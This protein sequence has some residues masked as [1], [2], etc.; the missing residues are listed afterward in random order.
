MSEERARILRLLEEGKIT[1]DQAARLIEALGTREPEE[2]IGFTVAHGPRGRWR[3]RGMADVDR[4]PDIVA[5]AVTSAVKAGF[6]PVEE[7][8]HEFAGARDLFVKSVSGD[9]EVAGG[10]E[11]RV[12]LSYSGGM[13]KSRAADEG[14]QVRSV[15]GDVEARMPDKGRLEVETVSGDVTVEGVKG[16]VFVKTVS[17]DVDARGAESGVRAASVS[18]DVELERVA[19]VLEVETRSGDVD[20]VPSGPVSGSLASKSGD[21]TLAVGAGD[22][23]LLE[24]ECEVEGEIDI[25]VEAPHEVLEQRE[26]YAKVKF[27]AGSGTLRARTRS[28]DITVRDKDEA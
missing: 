25:D 27:G 8:R 9:I 7:G 18:G 11:D 14:V 1:A 16:P 15:S 3:R 20:I 19:G 10:A 5:H 22:D 13:V 23:V 6:G 21:V 12:S 4:I 17:G 2:P 28:G 26:L 24:L